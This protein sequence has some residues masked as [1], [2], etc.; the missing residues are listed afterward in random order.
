MAATSG[1]IMESYTLDNLDEQWV[2]IEDPVS[3]N[4]FYA[5]PVSIKAWCMNTDLTMMMMII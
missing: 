5:K 2:E 4:I 3:G 1:P